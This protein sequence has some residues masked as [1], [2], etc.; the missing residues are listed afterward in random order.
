M[1]VVTLLVEVA[2]MISALLLSIVI[3]FGGIGM[4]CMG[5][6]G[7]HEL[8]DFLFCGGSIITLPVFVFV[9]LSQRYVKMLRRYARY[10]MWIVLL[11]SFVGCYIG[12]MMML[13]GGT[14]VNHD[15]VHLAVEC[16]SMFPVY[17]AFLN[18]VI[19]ETMLGIWS[20]SS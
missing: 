6:G 16:I 20:R 8:L 9:V 2:L 4:L 19:V 17:L 18:A 3:T 14:G 12:N 7:T 1:K 5:Y 15:Y 13:P 10:A 11:V